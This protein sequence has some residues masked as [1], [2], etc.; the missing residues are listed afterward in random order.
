MASAARSKT[1]PAPPVITSVGRS[2]VARRSAGVRPEAG[3]V[4]GER[5]REPLQP[6]PSSEARARAIPSS[7]EPARR[8][9][10][11]ERRGGE[12]I[13]VARPVAGHVVR[14]VVDG[15]PLD[16]QAGRGGLERQRPTRRD[17]EH[18][19]RP[20]R[21]RDQRLQVLDLALDGIRHRV[22]ALTPTAPRSYAIE[23][24]SRDVTRPGSEAERRRNRTYQRPGKSR[25]SVPLSVATGPQRPRL[26]ASSL[27]SRASRSG[28][29]RRRRS[30][31]CSSSTIARRWTAS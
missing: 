6:G 15:H 24:P 19:R 21:R 18:V 22:P 8:M 9:N 17:A 14:H 25:L 12:A 1:S 13:D 20:T 3:G 10:S 23:V 29:V 11:S 16:R 5:V 27:R 30:S 28:A 7:D 31:I 26:R 2:I 4:V